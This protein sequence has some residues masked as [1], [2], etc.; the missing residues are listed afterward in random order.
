MFTGIITSIGRV[1]AATAAGI[2]V[3]VETETGDAG[4]VRGGSVAC[5]G[6]CLTV[7]DHGPGW[8]AADLSAETRACTTA[9]AWTQGSAV[10]LERPLKVG[11]ELGGHMV[12]GHVDGVATLTRVE[13]DTGSLRLTADAPTKL[14]AFIAPK[15]AVTL[16][17]VSLTVNEVNGAA[18]GV[19]IIPH[20][21]QATTLGGA[22]EGGRVNLEIDPLARY[23][24]RMAEAQRP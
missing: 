2:E 14:M 12:L 15:G 1:R 5:S 18:F 4:F 23:V 16:D 8:F 24:A 19:S 22:R 13:E 10:N 21:R 11:D 6:V 20:T 17:G 7:T 3:E 9:A